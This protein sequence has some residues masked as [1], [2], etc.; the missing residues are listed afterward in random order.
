MS[1]YCAN[2]GAA[3]EASTRFCR[4]CG[5]PAPSSQS[6]PQTAAKLDQGPSVQHPQVPAGSTAPQTDHGSAS[7]NPKSRR[8]ALLWS[9]VVVV[10]LV[11][12]AGAFLFI[13]S[14]RAASDANIAQNIKAAFLADGSLRQCAIDITARNGIVT[15]V[16]SVNSNADKTNAVQIAS[17]QHGVAQ[18][19]DQLTLSLAGPLAATQTAP[20]SATTAD[21]GSSA[22]P[23][24]QPSGTGLGTG[25]TPGS[26]STNST[27]PS[28]ETS[29]PP[30]VVQ[31]IVQKGDTSLQLS[32]GRFYLYGMATG[33]AA[34]SSPFATGQYAQADDAAGQLAA[35]LAYGSSNQNSYT[36]STGYHDIAGVSISGSW[37]SFAAFFGS[38]SQSGA[39]SASVT[40]SVRE[41]SLVVVIGLD[42]GQQDIQLQGIQ[43]LQIDSGPSPTGYAVIGHAYLTPGQYTIVEHSSVLAAG[44]EP[45]HMADLI[46]A[47][48]FGSKD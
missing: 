38:N 17:Q 31:A 29:G 9:A 40:F 41:N 26:S 32:P 39:P 2:C 35:A 37:D 48:V 33:G 23:T 8:A 10:A 30:A 22:A 7:S 15:L 4:A 34:P 42:A 43:G 12:A 6:S 1:N 11:A 47:F 44:Q 20:M 13:R 18:V 24:I 16:G 46:G 21:T 5:T 28:A 14:R 25:A 27:E 3:I 45:D 19:I 36:T